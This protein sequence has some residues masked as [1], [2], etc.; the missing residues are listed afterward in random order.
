VSENGPREG[1]R[2]LPRRNPESGFRTVE[3]N[4][5]AGTAYR[6]L[7]QSLRRR[8]EELRS[9]AAAGGTPASIAADY[10]ARHPLEPPVSDHEIEVALQGPAAPRPAPGR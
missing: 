5:A 10:H 8:R 3:E 4:S 9:L 2:D 1:T 7:A 6:R